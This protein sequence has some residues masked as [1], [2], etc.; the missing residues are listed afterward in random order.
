MW[1]SDTKKDVVYIIASVLVWHLH[2]HSTHSLL[3]SGEGSERP[4]S[5]GE[6]YRRKANGKCSVIIR[7]QVLTKYILTT[8]SLLS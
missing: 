6:T 1:K 8:S 4:S 5:M 7:P 2:S 3:L